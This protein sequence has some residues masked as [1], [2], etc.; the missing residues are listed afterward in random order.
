MEGDRPVSRRVGWWREAGRRLPRANHVM[1]A[2]MRRFRCAFPIATKG[3]ATAAIEE[4]GSA[5]CTKPPYASANGRR[6]CS[7]AQRH[8]TA[9]RLP[10]HGG[11][12]I[13]QT[14]AELAHRKHGLRDKVRNST[15]R[16]RPVQAPVTVP[17]FTSRAANKSMV[18][19]RWSSWLRRPSRPGCIGR[20]GLVPPA[21]WP[22]G[23]LST[24]E[25][26]APSGGTR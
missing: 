9:R 8:D 6:S 12:G 15:A 24:H 18:S 26:R 21:A 7:R 5:T 10:D 25:T 4:P 3:A 11:H 20:T 16:C 17:A 14:E 19:C 2:A 13:E 1:P 23:S 22:C